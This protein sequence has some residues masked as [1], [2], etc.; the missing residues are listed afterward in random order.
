[1]SSNYPYTT[2]ALVRCHLEKLQKSAMLYSHITSSILA[3]LLEMQLHVTD[4]T[5]E[6]H[7]LYNCALDRFLSFKVKWWEDILPFNFKIISSAQGVR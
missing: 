5:N 2:S 1:M 4:V 3:V 6:W 7:N